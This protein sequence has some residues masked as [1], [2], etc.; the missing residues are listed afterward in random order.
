MQKLLLLSLVLNFTSIFTYSQN[1]FKVRFTIT[2]KQQLTPCN[3]R[4]ANESGEYQ[5]PDSTY[6]WKSFFAKPYPDYPS[7]GEFTI[8]LPPGRYTYE[9]DRGPEYYLT[10]GSFEVKNKDLNVNPVLKRIIDLKRLNWWSGELHIHR[11]PEQ[12][13]R[14]MQAG[15]L[16]VA[17][18][19][20]SWNEHY[21]D[22]GPSYDGSPKKLERNRYYT[23]TGSEDERSGGAI[24]VLN[25]PVPVNF[26]QNPK[27]E[28]PPLAASVERVKK[29]FGKKCW[30]DI[31]KPYWMDMPILLATGKINS[32]G[33]A[34]NHMNRDGIFD[35]EAWGKARDTVKY[36][37]PM[38]NGY[39]T[40]D[41]YYN[42]LNSGIKIAPSAGSASGVLL[43]PVG[44]N[45]VY[46]YINNGFSYEKWFD[47]ISKGR[48]FITNGPLLLC[49]ANGR[50][51]GEVFKAKNKINITINAEVFSRD[52]I[53]KI[54]IIKNGKIHKSIAADQLK[55]NRFSEGIT[56]DKSGWFLV[57][58]IAKKPGNFR[59][60]STAPYYVEIGNNKKYISKSSA[61]F[62]LDWTNDRANSIK[63]ES[64]EEKAEVFKYIDAAKT[65]W[66]DKVDNANAE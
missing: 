59:F 61:Q 14:L 46:A 3:V 60:A 50:Y 39:W 15:D 54:E 7:N 22:P 25:T 55:S 66:Q 8:S 1:D 43:N 18:V 23:T 38:G 47:K 49:K 6:Y 12:I 51:P 53:D 37:S 21:T 2:E 11:K 31:D 5:F 41:V 40:Q 20:S 45:R 63:V 34:N 32:T 17:P 9:I 27:P 26:S 19:I 35:N 33:I 30:I 28:Y 29:E 36:P 56:F 64:D 58:V 16:H 48:I 13:E 42:I 44:Y 57:R 10:R 52:A 62:F 24:L 4:I 65:F